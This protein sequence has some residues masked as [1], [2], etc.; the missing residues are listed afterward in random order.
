L[1]AL[2]NI[3]KHIYNWL[4]HSQYIQDGCFHFERIDSKISI[5]DYC[6]VDIYIPVT[7]IA[8]GSL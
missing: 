6:E 3:Y 2:M 8:S 7:H 5:D 1:K 4:L